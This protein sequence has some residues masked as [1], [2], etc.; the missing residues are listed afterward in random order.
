MCSIPIG[1]LAV[2]RILVGAGVSNV[3]LVIG[4]RL[5]DI[6]PLILLI[7]IPLTALTSREAYKHC[8]STTGHPGIR[9]VLMIFNFITRG[10][11]DLCILLFLIGVAVL[12][13]S[14]IWQ[15]VH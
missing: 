7:L 5:F 4:G 12:V 10:L 15:A 9:M 13:L 6:A 2:P 14:T 3:P 8:I 1:A 11:A